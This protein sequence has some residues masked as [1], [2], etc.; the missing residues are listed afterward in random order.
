[1]T[2]NEIIELYWQR[3]EK[4]LTETKIEYGALLRT[5]IGRICR[6]EEDVEECENDTYLQTW[7]SIPPTRPDNLRAFLCKIARNMG[8][9]CVEKQQAQKR[10]AEVVT[11]YEELEE[12]I[13]TDGSPEEELM[14][15]ELGQWISNFLRKEKSL[16]RI[17]FLKRYWYYESVADISRELDVSQA[18][19]KTTLHRM[20]EKMAKAM[21][22]QGMTG[23]LV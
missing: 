21:K 19:V 11:C 4:A 9:K 13:G 14:A 10:Q 5:V 20:R 8:L 22:A 3:D 12:V 17:I 7:N 15:Q 6:L 18:M 16:P 23:G 1:M 2:E